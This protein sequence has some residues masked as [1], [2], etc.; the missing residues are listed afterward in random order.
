METERSPRVFDAVAFYDAIA[1]LVGARIDVMARQCRWRWVQQAPG[2]AL[3]QII[4]LRDSWPRYV[5]WR[6]FAHCVFGIN[7]A[8]K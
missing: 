7:V 2:E 3:V 6:R 1:G 5:V 8:N 4:P